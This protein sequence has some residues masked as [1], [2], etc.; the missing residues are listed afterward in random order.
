MLQ[1]AFEGERRVKISDLEIKLPFPSFTLQTIRHLKSEYPDCL[2]YLCIGEDS[3]VN[4]HH[5]HNYREIL[6]ECTLLVVHR[7]GYDL[8][9]VNPDILERTVIVDHSPVQASSTEIREEPEPARDLRIPENVQRYIAEHQLY[10][11]K[12]SE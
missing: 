9:G 1:L 5:W 4:F 2:F 6:K 3:L 10:E 12:T 8:T 11:D 7:P